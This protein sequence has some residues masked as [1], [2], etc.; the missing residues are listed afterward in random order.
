MT[1]RNVTDIAIHILK[2]VYNYDSDHDE[3]EGSRQTKIIYRLYLSTSLLRQCLIWLTFHRL[4]IYDSIMRTCHITRK[5]MR[6]L[7]LC[8]KLDDIIT[9]EGERK[10]ELF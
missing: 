6:F 9:N 5:G 2:A 3:G 7:E 4:L 8:Q 10:D 1:Y